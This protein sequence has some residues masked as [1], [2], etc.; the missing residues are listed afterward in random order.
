MKTPKLKPRRMWANCYTNDKALYAH[1]S[2]RAAILRSF[3]HA[4]LNAVPVAVIPLDDIEALVARGAEAIAIGQGHPWGGRGESVGHVF[5]MDAR[6]VL[7]AIGV[8]PKQR[9][10]RK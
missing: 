3:G 9:K 5:R 8:L 1:P 10:G 2:K 4:S 6:N 7:T